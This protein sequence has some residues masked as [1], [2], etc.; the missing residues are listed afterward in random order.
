MSTL[1]SWQGR[2]DATVRWRRISWVILI[3]YRLLKIFFGQDRSV[4][5]VHSRLERRFKN[6]M[7]SYIAHRFGI[8]PD[9][10]QSAFDRIAE[11][12]VPLG[13][14]L[15]G[16]GFSYVPAVHD[17]DRSFTHINKCLFNDFFRQ[18]G[19]PELTSIFCALDSIWIDEL[20]Q[21]KYGV[22]FERPTTLAGGD[23]ACR[24]QFS[25]KLNEE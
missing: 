15:F 16:S 13:Q 22:R 17:N 20:H 12:Y 8:T 1:T 14:K 18:H 11:N 23:D 24:F 2:G 25:R 9:A 4:A 5:I 10:P 7:P 19:A 6:D 3:V 21:P